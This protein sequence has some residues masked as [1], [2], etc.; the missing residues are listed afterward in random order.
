VIAS[1][2]G[3]V[4]SSGTT[5][6]VIEVGG[7]GILVHLTAKTA[8]NMKPGKPAEVFTSLVVREDSLTLYGFDSYSAREMF[9]TLQSVSGIGPKVSQSALSIYEPGEIANAINGGEASV[10]ERIPG[11]GKKGAQRVILELKDKVS[12]SK[13]PPGKFDWRS[14]LDSALSGLGFTSKE[15]EKIFNEISNEVGSDVSTLSPS[16]LLKL[17]LQIKGRG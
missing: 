14:Q 17:A 7:V 12:G 13:T 2:S 15:I 1:L 4:K 6:A 10:L 9:E 16:D 3:I 8:G 11:L 5:S